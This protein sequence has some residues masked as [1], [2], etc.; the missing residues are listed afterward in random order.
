MAKQVHKLSARQV[1]TIKEPG[2][3]SDGGNLYL[4]VTPSGS[5][6]WSFMYRHQ[7]KQKEMGLGS[8][9]KA[10]VSLAAARALAQ[11]ARDALAD[12][13]DPLSDRKASEAGQQKIK[14]FGKA[15]DDKLATL[16]KKWRNDKHA[17]QW[18]Y[19]LETLA[20][21]LRS[22]PCHQIATEDV[23]KVLQ[24]VWNRIPETGARLRSRI[25]AVLSAAAVQGFCSGPNPARW[26]GHL[27]QVLS[28]RKATDRG[29][30]PSLPYAELPAFI[31]D[32]RTKEALAARA[33][34][35]TILCA[36]RTSETLKAK[37]PE[38]DFDRKLWI[39]PGE[40]MKM[41]KEHRIP[42]PPRALAI[43]KELKAASYSEWIFP[44]S[45]PRNPL[46]NM[47]MTMQM[48]RM[49][50]GEY[51]VH[52][53]R[54]SFKTWS[55]EETHFPIGISEA[56]LAHA[57]EDKTERAYDRSELIEKRRAL[58]LAWGEFLDGKKTAKIIP[59]SR[60]AK[61]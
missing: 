24:P 34:E 12:G 19:C 55:R 54:A 10:G 48:R 6:N 41:G 43:L 9:G 1:E 7:G 56:A 25:E 51:S 16:A 36:T 23:L 30:H 58:M 20:A 13:R 46:S 14:T 52:G 17:R 40:R 38:I 35:L 8:A 27:D 31:A 3:H 22:M 53:M 28:P 2:R 18:K 11:S 50:K 4:I 15:A 33:L 29:N 57:I 5:R 47:A 61:R 37:W 42:L 59:L 21:P 49:K 32:L 26:R 60:G 44:G 45:A 39:I